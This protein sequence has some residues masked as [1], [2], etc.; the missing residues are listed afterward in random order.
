MQ[1]THCILVV[2]L[3]MVDGKSL[4]YI[5]IQFN[6]ELCLHTSTD[7]ELTTSSRHSIIRWL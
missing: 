6:L 4:L 5:C 2:M 1:E 7:G 3:V